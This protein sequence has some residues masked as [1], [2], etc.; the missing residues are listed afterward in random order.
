MNPDAGKKS[1]NPFYEPVR[2][3]FAEGGKNV[4]RRLYHSADLFQGAREIIIRHE[5]QDYRLLITK[6]GKL[7]LNK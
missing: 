4:S 7:I 6:S 5:N 3:K 1:P 2:E